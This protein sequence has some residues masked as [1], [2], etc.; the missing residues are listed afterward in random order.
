MLVVGRAHPRPAH[1]HA[2]T[3]QRHRP[4]IVTVTLRDPVRIVLALRA[5]DLVDLELHQLMH[6]AEPDTDAEREQ[7]LPRCPHELAERLLNWRRQRTLGCLQVVTSFGAGTLLIAVPPVLADLVGACPLRNASGRGGSHHSKFYR[8][9][10]VAAVIGAAIAGT[11]IRDRL[12]RPRPAWWAVVLIAVT[13]VL[14]GFAAIGIDETFSGGAHEYEAAAS[15]HLT[16]D[17]QNAVPE[18]L[19]VQ[20]CDRRACLSEGDTVEVLCIRRFGDSGTSWAKLDLAEYRGAYVPAELLA[21][22][23]EPAP[24]C[25]GTGT[26]QPQAPQ[27]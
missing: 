2:A 26:Q 23:S 3:A 12:F 11:L 7:P 9:R 5:D 19:E 10:A 4:V 15:I 6:D 21:V 22:K 16:G 13:A 25:G 24:F 1:R 17:P 14:C 20:D 8:S 18:A 27:P